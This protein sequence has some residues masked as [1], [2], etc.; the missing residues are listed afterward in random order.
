MPEYYRGNSRCAKILTYVG[1]Q[2]VPGVALLCDTRCRQQAGGK[3]IL[4][5]HQ[6][7]YTVNKLA[8]LTLKVPLKSRNESFPEGQQKYSEARSLGCAVGCES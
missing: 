4:L 5:V 3:L 8:N 2:S 1:S 6:I 7:Q